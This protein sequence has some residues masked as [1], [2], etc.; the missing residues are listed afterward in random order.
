[1]FPGN[2]S[3]FLIRTR[4]GGAVFVGER[5]A[6]VWFAEKIGHFAAIH[7]MAACQPGGDFYA[8]AAVRR[9]EPADPILS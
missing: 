1:M 2:G 5:V 6:E 9:D 7:G 8:V 4:G 3:I